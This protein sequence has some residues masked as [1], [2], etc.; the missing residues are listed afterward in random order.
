MTLTLAW[1]GDGAARMEVAHVDRDG[2]GITATG[3]QLGGVYELRYRLRPSSLSLEVV[4][5]RSLELDL[6][7][8]DFFDVGWSPLF[9]SLPVI[10][11]GLLDPGP[12]RDYVM[13][14]V[15]V[16][17]LAVTRSEQRY[18]PLGNGVV[19]FSSGSFTAD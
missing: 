1:A 2:R 15:E 4:G 8:A 9:N 18:E 16:P 5:E 12:P 7:G 10:R 3:T 11:D 17:S 6:D 13:R 14:W 19:R